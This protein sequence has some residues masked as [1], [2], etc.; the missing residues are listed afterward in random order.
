MAGGG[1]RGGVLHCA[2]ER[3]LMAR[4]VLSFRCLHFL[5]A[6]DLPVEFAVIVC[7]GFLV[8]ALVKILVMHFGYITHG[9]CCNVARPLFRDIPD[10]S[11]WPCSA[12]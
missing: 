5:L 6:V 4:A 7:G 9:F 3:I 12:L 1:C 10:R 11:W 8:F 2:S